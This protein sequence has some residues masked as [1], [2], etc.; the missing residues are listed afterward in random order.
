MPQVFAAKRSKDV[1]T[2][3]RIPKLLV[4]CAAA[5]ALALPSLQSSRAQTGNSGSSFAVGGI[6][7][8]DGHVAFA[9]HINP[10]NGNVTGHVVQDIMGVSISGPVVDCVD[11][12]T[13]TAMV[14]WVVTRSENTTMFPLDSR[15]TFDVTDNGEPTMGMPTDQFDDRGV[16]DDECKRRRTTTTILR[17]NIVV[18]DGTP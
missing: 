5:L 15:R 3:R 17:G 1:R 4:L 10:K 11:I 2:N 13:N 14:T 12:E 7:T 9:A 18:K 8:I 6:T 16:T